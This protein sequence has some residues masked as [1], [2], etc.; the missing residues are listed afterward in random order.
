MMSPDCIVINKSDGNVSI[1][2]S[3]YIG[4]VECVGSGS[5]KCN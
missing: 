5:W 1:N 2:N 3:L 4:N